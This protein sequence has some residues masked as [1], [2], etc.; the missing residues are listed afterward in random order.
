[1]SLPKKKIKIYKLIFYAFLIAL[2]AGGIS[3]SFFEVAKNYEVYIQQPQKARYLIIFNIITISVLII[4][5]AGRLI[6]LKLKDNFGVKSSS[7][8]NRIII[9][10]CIV[11]IIPSIIIASFSA[12]VFNLGVKSWFNERVSSALNNSLA[13][14]EG[15][16]EEHKKNIKIDILVITNE[17]NRVYDTV[18]KNEDESLGKLVKLLA[19]IR[20]IPEIDII[21]YDVDSSILTQKGLKFISKNQEFFI[22]KQAFKNAIKEEVVLVD[23]DNPNKVRALAHPSKYKNTFI[24]VSRPIDKNVLYHIDKTK[25]S[26]DEYR[27]LKSK[28]NK[29]QIMF[30]MFFTFIAFFMA[31]IS[32][33]A[34]IFLAISISKPITDIVYATK[35]IS[36]GDYNFKLQTKEKNSEISLIAESF[37]KM[38]EKIAEQ[39]QQLKESTWSDLARKIA[40]EIKNPLTPIKLSLSRINNAQGAKKN[41]LIEK[42]LDTINRQIDNITKIVEEFDEFARM[43]PAKFKSIDIIKI[44]KTSLNTFSSLDKNISI[45]LISNFTSFTIDADDGHLLQVFNNIIKNSIEAIKENKGKGKIEIFIKEENEFIVITIKDTGGGIKAE[46]LSKIIE[47]YFTTKQ[48]GSGLGLSIV[49]KIIDEHKGKIYINNYESAGKVIGVITEIKFLKTL[50]A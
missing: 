25:D 21:K 7:F 13:V 11:S 17:L 15:Y 39:Q 28:I 8:R 31:L 29:G 47:P 42:Y 38:T 50:G 40:H 37:N 1:M 32:V 14:A 34:G 23:N 19:G 5:I 43:S 2:G 46:F 48:Y 18:K 24:L 41:Q 44:I 36:D 35:K 33:M 45:K 4:F 9:L 6:S 12:A 3:Y 16:L 10:F 27:L 30:L 20:K 26:V 22:D 49:R